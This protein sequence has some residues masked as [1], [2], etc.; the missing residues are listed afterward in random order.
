[1]NGTASTSWMTYSDS[2]F[3]RSVMTTLKSPDGDYSTRTSFMIR[4]D[5]FQS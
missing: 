2:V 3:T 1:M 4:P 5:M